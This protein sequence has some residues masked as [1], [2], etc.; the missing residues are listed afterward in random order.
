MGQHAIPSAQP[1]GYPKAITNPSPQHREHLQRLAAPP[2]LGRQA[3]VTDFVAALGDTPLDFTLD[4]VPARATKQLSVD[5]IR[6]AKMTTAAVAR[7]VIVL[8]PQ[9]D[10]E[11]FDPQQEPNLRGLP[12]T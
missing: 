12:G 8:V 11:E 7:I 3:T 2:V 9:L 6:G 1:S 5:I 10:F 4:T